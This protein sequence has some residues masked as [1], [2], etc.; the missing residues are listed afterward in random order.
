MDRGP[1]LQDLLQSGAHLLAMQDDAGQ[2]SAYGVLRPGR[3][4]WQL[5]PMVAPRVSEVPN[6]LRQVVLRLGPGTDC[7]CDV[8]DGAVPESWWNAVG[9]KPSRHLRR[10][11]RPDFAHLLCGPGVRC[12]A[13]FE[14]G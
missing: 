12:V 8:P 6:L 7:L 10:M 4:A 13:G 9:L 1:L 3:D 2:L 11:T 14:L 5:G